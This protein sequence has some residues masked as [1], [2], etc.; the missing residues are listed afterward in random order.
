MATA[1]QLRAIAKDLRAGKLQT[2]YG[3]I[4]GRDATEALRSALTAALSE[5]SSSLQRL[6]YLFVESMLDWFID[7]CRRSPSEAREN[8]YNKLTTVTD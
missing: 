5:D 4:P 6:D 7:R 2:G 3:G 8:L 1:A